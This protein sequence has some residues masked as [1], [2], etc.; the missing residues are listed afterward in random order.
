M[1]TSMSEFSSIFCLLAK[2]LEK[3]YAKV[4]NCI[5]L[6]PGRVFLPSNGWHVEHEDT[7]KQ[8]KLALYNQVTM[9]HVDPQKRHCINTNASDFI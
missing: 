5:Y 8:C 1:H 9:S 4:G 2:I 6:A 7:L 3:A